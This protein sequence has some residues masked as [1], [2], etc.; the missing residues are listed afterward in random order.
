MAEWEIS[1]IYAA[2]EFPADRRGLVIGVIQ[3]FSALGSVLCAVA[4]PL[5]LAT[6]FGWRAVQNTGEALALPPARI[7]TEG[8]LVQVALQTSW[9]DAVEGPADLRLKVSEDCVRP[10]Q[11]MDGRVSVTRPREGDGRCRGTR[12]EEAPA[13]RVTSGHRRSESD[14]HRKNE[15][16]FR[17]GVAASAAGGASAFRTSGRIRLGARSR[18]C[19]PLLPDTAAAGCEAVHSDPGRLG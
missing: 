16:G 10:R 11:Q 3:A 5:L 8:E 6:S 17:R 7:E 19:V 1:R 18:A 14:R 4:A 2:E 9:A 13:C 12:R 15:R